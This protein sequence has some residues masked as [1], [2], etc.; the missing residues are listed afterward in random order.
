MF[1]I[2]FT[3]E[4]LHELEFLLRAR[5]DTVSEIRSVS[6]FTEAEYGD[7][8]KRLKELHGKLEY[9]LKVTR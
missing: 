6:R 5:L 2:N 3:E 4:E 7:E 1:D 8:Y 9:F